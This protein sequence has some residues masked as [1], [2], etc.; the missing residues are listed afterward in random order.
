[1]QVKAYKEYKK[2]VILDE[3]DLLDN[4]VSMIIW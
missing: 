2:K 3:D 1:M 4:I